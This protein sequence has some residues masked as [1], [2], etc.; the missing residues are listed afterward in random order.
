LTNSFT[1]IRPV[2]EDGDAENFAGRDRLSFDI[3][4]L[5][6]LVIDRLGDELELEHLFSSQSR[7][8][9]EHQRHARQENGRRLGRKR[10]EY[11]RL[12]HKRLGHKL[13]L[14]LV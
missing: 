10:L 11:K 1:P 13:L 3:G 5:C 12:R 2:L 14:T 8:R 9:R 6:H 4:H 7:G